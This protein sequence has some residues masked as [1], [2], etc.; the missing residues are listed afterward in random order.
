[1]IYTQADQDLVTTA[2]RELLTGGRPLGDALRELHG[3]RGIGLMW[4]VP[5]VVAACG[6]A[7]P[8]AQRV[9]VRETFD[10]GHP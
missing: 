8:D 6:L 10:R 1:M 4:L 2:L 5:A 9:V 7:T 3:G